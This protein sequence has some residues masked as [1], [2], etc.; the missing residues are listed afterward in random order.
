MHLVNA[1]P[2]RRGVLRTALAVGGAGGLATLI[3][4]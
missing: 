2:T 3:D 1:R 4:A